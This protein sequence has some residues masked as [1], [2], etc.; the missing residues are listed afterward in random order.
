MDGF[1]EAQT[2]INVEGMGLKQVPDE[3]KDLNDLVVFEFGGPDPAVLKSSLQLYLTKNK[4]RSLPPALFAFSR[5]NVLGLRHN[6]LM[7]IPESISNLKNLTDLYVGTNRLKY[8]PYAILKLPK[9]RILLTGPNPFIKIPDDAF[10]IDQVDD[11]RALIAVSKFHPIGEFE[12]VPSLTALALNAIA[13][14]DVTYQET[15]HWKH[16]VPKIFHPAIAKAIRHGKFK[17]MC[18]ECKNI[19][20]DPYTETFEWWNILGNKEIPFKKQFC[21][22][23]C[24]NKWKAKI[25]ALV[26]TEDIEL[27]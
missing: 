9:L 5:L 7:E 2:N 25:L 24:Y 8:L 15:R 4:S 18:S 17:A 23:G 13:K 22:G 10:R 3:S 21:S 11:G 1:D 19:V 20:V 16:A 6:K 27:L 14:Y 26:E 12:A